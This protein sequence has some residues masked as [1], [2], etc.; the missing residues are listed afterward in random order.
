VWCGVARRGVAGLEQGP[1]GGG[2]TKVNMPLVLVDKL[3]DL[4]QP[5]T[6]TQD[7]PRFH[8]CNGLQLVL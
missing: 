5:L 4:A 1:G 8:S 7:H 2:S 6:C 3:L